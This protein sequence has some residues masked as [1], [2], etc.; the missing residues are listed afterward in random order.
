MKAG[1][2]ARLFWAGWQVPQV[3]PFPLNVSLKKISLPLE[4]RSLGGD[5]GAS[6]EE[7]ADSAPTRAHNTAREGPLPYH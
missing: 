5:D 1:S 4:T 7:S 2:R 3:L 6:Q